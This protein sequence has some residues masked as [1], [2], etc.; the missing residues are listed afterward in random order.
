M[1]AFK[2]TL[3]F[4]LL[5]LIMPAKSVAQKKR[6]IKIEI[7]PFA[8]KSGDTILLNKGEDNKQVKVSH[9]GVTLWADKM[10]YYIERDFIEAFGN[11]TV[12]QGDTI[13]MTSKELEYNGN[14]EIAY[15]KGDVVL[16]EPNSVLTSKKLFFDRLKQEAFYN[17]NGKVVRDSSGTITSKIG[18]YYFETKKYQFAKNVVLKS[19][20]YTINTK[21]LDFYSETGHAYLFGP[22]TITTED[23][24]TSCEKCFY[25][26]EQKLGY[27]VKNSKIDYDNRTLLGDSLYFNNASKFASATNNIVMTDTINNTIIKGEYGEVHK[28]KDYAF[29]TKRALAIFV[30]EN[31]TTHIHSDTISVR[32]KA[33][34]RITKAYYNAKIL[35]SNLSAKADSIHVNHS[36]GTT[37]LM[38]L[39]RFSKKD[40][41]A[42]KRNPVLWNFNNQMTGDTILLIANKKTKT[43]DTLKVFNDAYIIAL[44]SLGGGYNQVKGKKLIGVFKDNSLQTIDII[45]NAESIF[46]AYNDNDE[47]IAIDRT[48][49]G[50][51]KIFFKNKTINR[52]DRIGKPDGTMYASKNF[53]EDLQKFRGFWQRS[54]EAPK[55]VNDLFSDDPPLKRP[56]IKGLKDFVPQEEFIE[57]ELLKRINSSA[58]IKPTK[59]VPK[60]G[61]ITPSKTPKLQQTKKSP[62]T[63]RPSLKKGVVQKAKKN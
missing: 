13:I 52:I 47:L 24:K 21:V 20:D 5:G 51:M 40:A 12:N 62:P 28:N 48:V 4:T 30:R 22:S 54:E 10:N 46:Y 19:P 15:A 31:D 27:A 49:S 26:T 23:S 9:N 35:K 50:Q 29:V 57:K 63:N 58:I 59:T 11:V 33:E 53:T 3:F 44:D 18:R 36:K 55:S 42:A 32:G 45:K 17:T 37:K 16:T 56:I 6:R 61:N 41:F 34:N 39:S 14:I 8:H 60:K 7:S 43:L 25:D 1:N 2:L 38:N